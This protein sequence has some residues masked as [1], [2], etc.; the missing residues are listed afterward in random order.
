MSFPP[1][2]AAS[3]ST[4]P[5]PQRDDYSAADAARKRLI[6]KGR[7]R[8]FASLPNLRVFSAHAGSQRN[9]REQQDDRN[10]GGTSPLERI[11]STSTALDAEDEIELEEGRLPDL[12]EDGKNEYRWAILFENQR[13]YFLVQ[14]SLQY[15]LVMC[16]ITLFSMALYSSSTLL[17]SDPKAFTIPSITTP[18]RRSR[19]P[20]ITPNTYP[21]P[22]GTWCWVSKEWMIDM[23]HEGEVQWDGF[24][25]NWCFRTGGWRAIV[26]IA[27]AGGWVRRR[28]WVRLMMKP[29][30][31][32]KAD[33]V[34]DDTTAGSADR[35]ADLPLPVKGSDMSLPYPGFD[36]ETALLDHEADNVWKGHADRDWERCHGLMKTLGRDGMKLELW[37]IWLEGHIL[38]LK[39]KGK[40]T[41]AAHRIVKQWTEDQEPLPSEV[42]RALFIASTKTRTPPPL[43][44]IKPV[45]RAHVRAL[46]LMCIRFLTPN[47]G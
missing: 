2:P 6:P 24:E 9:D 33:D 28:M 32:P 38:S 4:L 22:D 16:S 11:S 3:A 13:G 17:P 42:A 20:D 8:F 10:L 41:E 47:T 25:Y 14:F 40:E 7:F 12:P 37:K 31:L 19:Q 27:G 18:R 5:L 26:G 23:R 1:A 43:D 46:S 34:A 35:T 30:K 15:N 45:L 36:F 39:G 29:A 44:Y 21:L